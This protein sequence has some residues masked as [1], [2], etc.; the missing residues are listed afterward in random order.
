MKKTVVAML[1]AILAAGS[2]YALDP[3]QS[4]LEYNGWFRYTNQS[5]PFKV[6]SPTVSRS[7]LERD[8][9]RAG[10]QWTNKLYSKLTLDFL[11][12]SSY[13][14]GF[15]TR[16]KEAYVDMVT[17]IKDFNLTAGMQKVYFGEIYSWD[18][19][20]PD[21]ELADDR[22]VCASA[23][24]GMTLNGFLP[25]GLG[26]LQLGAYNG[27]GYKVTGAK[28]S[29]APMLLANL[30]LTPIA[31]FQV[32]ASVFNKV[33]D[34]SPYSN[35]KAGRGT[36]ADTTKFFNA[37]TANRNRFAFAPMAK[38]AFGPVSLTGEYIMYSYTR[39]LS[40]YALTRD[41]STHK[42]TDST[43]TV[44][45]KNYKMSGIDLMPLVTL[46]NSHLDVF[47]RFS[48]WQQ[49]EQ[50]GDSMPE[51]K[52]KSLMRYGLGFNWH[53]LKR[54]GGSKPAVAFQFAWIHEQSDALKPAPSTDK[55][56]PTN[57]F[58]AQFRLEW[59][60]VLNAN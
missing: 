52:A 40:Y 11:S 12:S 43:L 53:F 8:Y 16:I 50:S 34:F 13:A 31:G 45:N 55:V 37:D 35:G 25:S 19:T 9:L 32:G 59:N 27:E 1:L 48:T 46:M 6:T 15:S 51:N 42:V 17:P 54:A 20:H 14:D 22:G 26:E 49:K 23:D 58:M 33:K 2:V 60:H 28:N 5:S 18:Y 41:T 24:Y 36:G 4:E 21:K 44:S 38:V 57:T 3:G 39:N 10:H 7:T 29:A 56:D 47:G 30:R